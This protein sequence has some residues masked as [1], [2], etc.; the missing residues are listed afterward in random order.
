[1]SNL[2]R[3]IYL[4]EADYQT[5][6]NAGTITKE[7]RTI[8]YNANDIYITPDASADKLTH[9]LTFGAGQQYVFDGSE[10]VVVPVYTGEY[11]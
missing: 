3:I 8:T 11:L 4:S 1:M 9:T 6:I 5:L 10:D 7:G 2:N